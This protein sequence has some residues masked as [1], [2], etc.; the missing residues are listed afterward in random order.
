MDF[1]SRKFTD[2]Q[3]II[4]ADRPKGFNLINVEIYH[5]NQNSILEEKIHSEEA[6]I[7]NNRWILKNVQYLNC[8]MEF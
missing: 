7:E 6:N 3:R 1:G 8:L 5:L 2:K 4:S